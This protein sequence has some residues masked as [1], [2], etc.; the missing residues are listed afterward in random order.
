MITKLIVLL[1]CLVLLAFFAWLYVELDASYQEILKTIEHNREI[2]KDII[3]ALR[4]TIATLK[5]GEG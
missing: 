1:F 2:D 3:L 4:S 5:G